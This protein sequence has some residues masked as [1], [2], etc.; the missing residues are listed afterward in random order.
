L[1]AEDQARNTV[2]G[3]CF[4]VA[5][6]GE[7]CDDD[8]GEEDGFVTFEDVSPG[9][10]EVTET[11]APD[12]FVQIVGS[13]SITVVEADTND[14]Y[15][16]HQ[17]DPNAGTGTATDAAD[18]DDGAVT[19]S[20]RISTLDGEG[21]P[22]EG[23]CYEVVAE[24]TVEVCDDGEGDS[25]PRGGLIQVDDLAEGDYAVRQSEIPGDFLPAAD[26]T[27]SILGGRGN[28]GVS[29]V[30]EL[31]VVNEA[32]A[33]STGSLVVVKLDENG[34]AL[35][36]A[37]FELIDPLD[38]STVVTETCDE[39]GD[40]ADDG[41]IGFS[42]VPSGTYTLRE[43]RIPEGYQA[44]GDQ[45]VTVE[46]T[47]VT[48]TS[49]ATPIPEE[50]GEVEVQR[51]GED[52]ESLPGACFQLEAGDGTVTGPV[53]D[54]QPGD[55]DPDGG[56][57]VFADVVEGTYTLTETTTPDD[58][59]VAE[60]RAVEVESG[61]TTDVEVQTD[62]VELPF[63]TLRVDFADAD[64]GPIV[65]ACVNVVNGAG[66]FGPFCDDRFDGVNDGTLT[67]PD[68]ESGPNT[69]SVVTSP[70]GYAPA[71]DQDTQDIEIEGGEES[72]LA[73]TFDASFGTVRVSLTNGATGDALDGAC[74]TL[75]GP[76]SYGPACDG[77]DTDAEP[78]AGVILIGDV[79]TG[80]YTVT[81]TRTPDGFDLAGE[82]SVDV[83]RG[84]TAELAVQ[85]APTAP[86]PGSVEI[87]SLDED[88]DRLAGACFGL[89]GVGRI[90]D[91]AAVCDGEAGDGAGD[92][93]VI[94]IAG[95]TPGEYG[96]TETRSPDGNVAVSG[97]SLRVTEGTTT[98]VEVRHEV[99]PAETGSIV[100][101]ATGPDGEAVE[102]ACY[103]VATP[104]DAVCDG[105]EDDAATEAGVVRFDDLD[106]GDYEVVETTAPEGFAPADPDRQDATV[107]GGD[108][109][110]LTFAHAVAAVET[111]GVR[112]LVED[113]GGNAVEGA[114]F[115]L[116]GEP[117]EFGPVC[118]NGE[119]D[120]DDAVG[121]VLFSEV[122][123]G[124][125]E[126]IQDGGE[127][128]AAAGSRSV[129]A[130]A[131]VTVEVLVIIIIDEP[132]AADLMVTKLDDRG[133]LLGGAC[134]A[135]VSGD[136][137]IEICDGDENDG[138]GTTGEIR[139]DDLPT[140]AYVLVE[141]RTPEGYQET[142]D[143]EVTIDGGGDGLVTITV[144]NEPVPDATG[145]V[146]VL[147]VDAAGD[148]LGGACFAL[149][150]GAVEV[151]RAC[152]ED[153]DV[154]DDG[155]IG[156]IGVTPGTYTLRE[157]RRPSTDYVRAADQPVTV[158][159]GD[160]VELT[161][162]NR[163]RPAT[164]VI[165]KVD[166]EG[167]R[168]TGS[169]FALVGST[170]Y[171]RCDDDDL[172]GDDGDITFA[173]IVP[174]DYDLIETVAPAGYAGAADQGLTLAPG[175]R[176]V[177]AV[178]NAPLPPPVEAGDLV[179]A[180]I[181]PDSAPLAGS[182]FALLADG[183]F[184]SGPR[185][186]A[187][188]G[189]ADGTITFADVAVGDYTLR[190]TRLPSA[191]YQA[192]D[193]RAVS[194]EDGETTEV[195]VENVFKRGRVLV[196]KVNAQ[197]HLLQG[198]CFD[199]SPDGGDARCT[200]A[201]GTVVFSD[202]EPGTYSLE[203]TQAP[204]GYL[205]AAVVEGIVVEPGATTVVTVEDELAPPPPNTGTLQVFKFYCPAGSDGERTIIFDSSDGDASQLARTSNCVQGN[206]DFT[207]R[208]PD[209]AL[210]EV[211]FSTGDDGTY[212]RGLEAGTYVLREVAPDLAGEG[213][214]TL[215]IAANQ[216]TTIVV[217]N[218][219]APPAPAPVTVNVV[220]YTC[221]P[222]FAGTIYADFVDNCAGDDQRTNNVTFRI[223]GAVAARGI[224]GDG[225]T[226]G[227]T[228]FARIPA[229]TYTLSEDVYDQ[230]SSVY[231]FCGV[232]PAAPTIR[233]FGAS[234]GFTL[235][236]G[237]TITCAFFNVPDD[238]TET[239]GA[240]L[241]HKFTCPV[242]TPPSGY[243]FEASCGR[244]ATAAQFSLGV[245]SAEVRGF[246]PR[247][248]GYTNSDG[249][250][251]ISRLQ[252]GRYELTEI[253]D[254]WCYAE[255]DNVNRDGDVIVEAGER[256]EVFIYN[257]SP[258]EQEPNTGTGTTAGSVS[259]RLPGGPGL[260]LALGGAGVA[261]ALAAGTRRRAMAA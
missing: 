26:Q 92:D 101:R 252:P 134:F 220:K 161:V 154:A 72:T 164:L 66:E 219:V 258:V 207:L 211:N 76:G 10:V 89:T 175:Q 256:T 257:C 203:E 177:L 19:G 117:G 238:L 71:E 237:S 184:V 91:I 60:D 171:E 15:V 244:Q 193:D 68:V 141:S 253:G 37:C 88:G 147:K 128:I 57:V 93:G 62:A 43:T 33:D 133:Q 210:G 56:T 48:V 86:D 172:A 142:G 189:A 21:N 137:E 221:E 12:G 247:M 227:V 157:V 53:C 103:T 148:R 143:R 250:L 14:F 174:G 246:V 139:F 25:E 159:A 94:A 233:S 179:I 192:A 195:V 136:E 182:C 96:L 63:G 185:C 241:V 47:E 84:E 230:A 42:D 4:E 228:A 16:P 52:G 83:V 99:T 82:A 202:L 78:D 122:P 75:N 260:A 127:G 214:E 104:R 100:V 155:R 35:G 61:E 55:G 41:R 34:N 105:D 188:D 118:D 77:E 111:G 152:D 245:Y 110:E 95:V 248:T 242:E 232:D 38:D 54:D 204:A 196:R 113:D 183:R 125:Y 144:V 168:L 2:T 226:A 123:A 27:V 162:E 213:S 169:C 222:G 44:A 17:R 153:G 79:A 160:V 49:A 138:D 58:I 45:T 106:A 167:S 217:I 18:D 209:G 181:G 251:R 40:V 178:E 218:E 107:T 85:N 216:L 116:A 259:R 39:D 46:A 197:G 200:A 6:E 126:V 22:I 1:E 11:R 229:G 115:R 156:L 199:L 51:Q 239:T 129:T 149:L 7:A 190:E 201:S 80:T 29:A 261:L 67:I 236:A 64:G 151:A 158:T 87:V 170:R 32:S 97:Q 8:D 215:G 255:S 130:V 98:R 121:V 13:F 194:I 140:G 28:V 166:G 9:T 187:S 249:V 212:A 108:V 254:A 50:G 23:A 198:A 132:D 180:K 65:G 3:V 150:R 120:G 81:Q 225:G 59:E 165:E 31:T 224:T 124:A 30:T 231:S 114:C 131:G 234:T 186:D 36:G 69:V 90:A 235:A 208:S 191:D 102:G 20:L 5:G 109:T 176:L 74:F 206:A 73:V 70:V 223:S 145:D 163:L 243:D 24:G 205:G 173:G 112:V 240:I 146:V 119:G 135:L